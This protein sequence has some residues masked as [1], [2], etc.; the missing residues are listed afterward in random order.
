MPCRLAPS[1]A[2][3]LLLA[4]TGAM[5]YAAV[6]ADITIYRCTDAS[7]HLTLRDTPCRRG[8]TQQSRDMLRPTD[9]PR[10]LK[11]TMAAT[12]APLPGPADAPPHYVVVTPP[13]PMYECVTY[14]GEHYLSDTAEGNPRWVELWALGYPVAVRSNPLGDN[15]GGPM[16]RPP[17]TGPGP[18]RL[19]V[20]V[21]LAMTP[22]SWIRDPCYELSPDEI[23]EHLRDRH[24][25][26]GRRYNSALQGDRQRIDDEQ[27]QIARRLDHECGEY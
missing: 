18:P 15:V 6:A 1:T 19:P 22:G 23:C 7:G 20:D 11:V 3:L 16:P 12:E 13:R 4:T 26:L 17:E 25:E 21:G 2:L 10:R 24:Y 9:P 14:E 5:G 8:E 27:Q